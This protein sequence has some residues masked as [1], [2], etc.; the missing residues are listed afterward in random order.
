MD[1]AIQKYPY[2]EHFK[3]TLTCN[4]RSEPRICELYSKTF[5]EGKLEQSDIVKQDRMHK[6]N[7]L[8]Q[9]SVVWVDT[10]KRNDK[11]DR[12]VGT[13]KQNVCNAHIIVDLLKDIKA[14]ISQSHIKNIGIITPYK[15]QAELLRNKLK[16]I[17]A[18]CFIQY[19]KV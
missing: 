18:R 15:A 3:H 6:L 5:Y 10:S 16:D 14:N 7:D 2:V 12:Q 11:E 8:F 4:Y 19:I 1:S 9:S 17:R 13:G